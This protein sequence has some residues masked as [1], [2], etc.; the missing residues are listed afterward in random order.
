MSENFWKGFEKIAA[1]R[2]EILGSLPY[3]PISGVATAIGAAVGPRSE[4]DRKESNEKD[5]SNL[6]PGVGGYRLG[7]RFAGI[8]MEKE[9]RPSDKKKD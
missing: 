3:G 6:I 5:W 7:R 9:E 1:A 4:K 8:G 2:S